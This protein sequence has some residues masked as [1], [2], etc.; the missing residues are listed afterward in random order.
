MPLENPPHRI[1][2]RWWR[3]RAYSPWIWTSPPP[4]RP[5]RV[6]TRLD[7]EPPARALDPDR[8]GGAGQYVDPQLFPAI[9]RR[10]GDIANKWLQAARI[11]RGRELLEA[12][13]ESID[14]IGRMSGQGTPANFRR[15]FSQHVGVMPSQYRRMYRA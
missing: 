3:R 12:S 4:R 15:I 14:R 2:S 1:V 8:H 9:H 6:H 13:D 11:D 5:R 10:D 7:S